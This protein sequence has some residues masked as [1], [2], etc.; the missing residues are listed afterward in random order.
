MCHRSSGP[1]VDNLRSSCGSKQERINKVTTLV[2]Y[3]FKT[4]LDYEPRRAAGVP[5]E[6][7]E[8]GDQVLH[9]LG[10]QIVLVLYG[11]PGVHMG[12]EAPRLGVHAHNRSSSEQKLG[13]PEGLQ[14]EP[15]AFA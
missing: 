12:A 2:P 14:R 15:S 8:L 10:A 9:S 3:L 1:R 5:V 6:L 7:H 13:L 4:E 11:V